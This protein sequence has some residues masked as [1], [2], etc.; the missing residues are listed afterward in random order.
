MTSKLV[1]ITGLL[2]LVAACK[3]PSLPEPRFELPPAPQE[4]NEPA[5]PLK[6]I[7]I[8]AETPSD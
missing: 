1:A 3:S 6:K 5:P 4:L 8:K 2:A 7:D